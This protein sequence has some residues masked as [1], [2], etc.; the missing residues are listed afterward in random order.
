[1]NIVV[2]AAALINADGAVL[3]QK[4]AVGRPMSGLW[5]FPGGKI[6]A[7]ERPELALVRELREELGIVVAAED[8]KPVN[9]A[10]AAIE[11][12]HL[13]LLLYL[14]RK[15]TGKPEALDAEAIKWVPI[16]ALYGLAMPPADAPLVD[17]LAL[18]LG[19]PTGQE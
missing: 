9:F 11:G 17:S 7:D 6:E 2:V 1:M 10:S 18:L 14:C 13:I 5:E 3:V 8:V 15:W 12:G 4:R 16:N 19:F